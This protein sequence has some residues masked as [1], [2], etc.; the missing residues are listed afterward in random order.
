MS[1]FEKYVILFV[2]IYLGAF[3]F[4]S[5]LNYFARFIPQPVPGDHLGATFMDVT[6]NM[7]LFQIAKVVEMLAGACL[8]LNIFVP[9]A[10]IALFPITFNIFVMNTFISP[11]EHIKVSGARNFIFHLTLFA[12]YA[13]HYLPLLKWRASPLPIWRRA[14]GS[15]SE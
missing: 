9:A 13:R 3:N 1:Y 11:L 14:S 8:L 7:G 4:A 10:L 5:G 2:R 12:G 6:L 15:G